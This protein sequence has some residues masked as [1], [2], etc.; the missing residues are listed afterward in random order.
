MRK[1]LLL[2]T[3]QI[4][5]VTLLWAQRTVTGRVTDGQGQPLANVSVLVKGTST[6]TIT[7]TDG[8][9]TIS[10]TGTRPVLIFSFVDKEKQEV[11]VGSSSEL[12]VELKST[13]GALDEVVVVGYAVQRKKDVAGA[14][15]K[16]RGDDIGNLPIHLC[17][18]YAGKSRRGGCSCHK[19]YSRRRSQC[20][21]QGGW[22]S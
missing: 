20:Y 18:S 19:R 6:G 16:I 7:R 2:I 14:I 11:P 4:L 21:H 9:Y 15:S 12:N 3:V 17:S 8:N 13:E 22:L 1:R 10:V 5:F